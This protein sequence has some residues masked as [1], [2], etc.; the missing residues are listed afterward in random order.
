MTQAKTLLRTYELA[1]VISDA[2][3][4]A[5]AKVGHRR[6]FVVQLVDKSAPKDQQL[7]HKPVL[8]CRMTPWWALQNRYV[9]LEPVAQ[10]GELL[11]VHDVRM[12]N[13]QCV[14]TTRLVTA[15]AKEFETFLE[16]ATGLG[17][18]AKW[19][20]KAAF[21]FPAKLIDEPNVKRVTPSGRL[22]W[23]GPEHQEWCGQYG[24]A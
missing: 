1:A 19:P 21:P 6:Y 23:T 5:T 9:A 2:L 18:R 17:L 15:R 4:G 12:R 24:L 10:G 13:F 14:S 20:S 7:V 22:L 11:D 8:V 3:G 16:D